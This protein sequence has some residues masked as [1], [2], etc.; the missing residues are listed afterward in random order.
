MAVAAGGVWPPATPCARPIT[1]HAGHCAISRKPV[2]GIGKNPALNSCQ[3][4]P[5]KPHMISDLR[6]REYFSLPCR[7]TRQMKYLTVPVALVAGLFGGA[8]SHYLP[9]LVQAPK[10]IATTTT[11]VLSAQSFALVDA[12][13]KT[14]AVFM[15]GKPSRKGTT[16]PV[17]LYDAQGKEIWHAGDPL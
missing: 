4:G 6:V 2:A 11:N 12:N 16:S 9:P 13:G 10:Q 15:A 3:T 8:A 17:V 5:P 14:V 1:R 7:R